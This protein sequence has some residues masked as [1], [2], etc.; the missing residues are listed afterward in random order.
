MTKTAPA[1]K[2]AKIQTEPQIIDLVALVAAGYEVWVKES[3]FDYEHVRV[4]SVVVIHQDAAGVQWKS[5]F[6]LYNGFLSRSKPRPLDLSNGWLCES[7]EAE[8]CRLAKRGYTRHEAPEPEPA[9]KRRVGRPRK[10]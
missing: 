9:P 6:Q 8:L 5:A 7:P 10:S 1:P 2:A 3:K 4:Q